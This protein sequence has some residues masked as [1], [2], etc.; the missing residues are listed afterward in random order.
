MTLILHIA[1]RADWEAASATGFYEHSSLRTEG[2]IHC[3]TV[4]Q[5]IW[6]AN[7]FFHGQQALVLLCV[8]SDRLQADL[9]YDEVEGVGQF[10]H[11]YGGINLEAVV[12]VL[13]FEPNANGE[14]ELPQALT[15]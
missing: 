4:Q 3:S 7:T 6:V 15:V 8:E 1:N 12:Q 13:D 9:R 2:F 10:P 14:F 11:V 5:I